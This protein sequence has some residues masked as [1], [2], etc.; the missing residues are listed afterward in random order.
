LRLTDFCAKFIL[1]KIC[2]TIAAVWILSF[3]LKA[4]SYPIPDPKLLASF[5]QVGSCINAEGELDIACAA[6]Q[7]YLIIYAD[8]ISNFDGIQFFENA[9]FIYLTFLLPIQQGA[10]RW[11]EFI[12]PSAEQLIIGAT[13]SFTLPPQFLDAQFS[14]LHLIYAELDEG[15]ITVVGLP[16]SV[17]S[18]EVSTQG[19]IWL[20]PPVVKLVLP[21]GLPN[22]IENL[23]ISNTELDVPANIRPPTSLRSLSIVGGNLGNWCGALELTENLKTLNF[24]Q[25]GTSS[26]PDDCLPKLS[27]HLIHLNASNFTSDKCAA[28]LEEELL[29]TSNLESLELKNTG[30][31]PLIFN[32]SMPVTLQYLSVNNAKYPSIA[33]LPQNLKSLRLIS[34][35]PSDLTS[36]LLP[37]SVEQLS[38]I[39][40]PIQKLHNLPLNL[41][42]LDLNVLEISEPL[43]SKDF[44][45]TL[46]S[47]IMGRVSFPILNFLPENLKY[48]DLSNNDLLGIEILPNNLQH[49]TL[50]NQFHL[51]DI[52]FNLQDLDIKV[53]E[54]INTALKRTPELPRGLETLVLRNN[55]RLKCLTTLPSTLSSFENQF[56]C[57]PNETNF[58]KFSLDGPPCNPSVICS[59]GPQIFR[60]KIYV[61]VNYNGIFDEG[62]YPL[63]HSGFRVSPEDTI[64]YTDDQGRFN[65][66]RPIY[67]T[68][69]VNFIPNPPFD[70]TAIPSSVS[71]STNLT[72][73]GGD[74]IFIPYTFAS[75]WDFQV[76]ASASSLIPGENLDL[77]LYVVNRGA[78]AFYPLT[79]TLAIPPSLQFVSADITPDIQS[80]S[81]VAWT[82]DPPEELTTSRIKIKLL[83]A[84]TLRTG[85]I[86][87]VHASLNG[88][89]PDQNQ[90][91]N[92]FQLRMVGADGLEPLKKYVNKELIMKPIS[93]EK[94]LVYV[95]RFTN[96]QSDTIKSIIL[97]DQLLSQ[98]RPESYRLISSS[99]DFTFD[100]QFENQL[101]FNFNDISLPPVTENPYEAILEVIF[102]VLA[103]DELQVDFDVFNR[104]EAVD[105]S[106][107]NIS[108]NQV[109]TRIRIN[110]SVDQRS[111]IGLQAFPNPANDVV[112]LKWN[113]IQ[114]STVSILNS[115]GQ[116]VKTIVTDGQE[117]SLQVG[118][119]PAGAYFI[120][121]SGIEGEGFG[122][123]IVNR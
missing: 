91:N 118:D 10:L 67:K 66:S 47:L 119:W 122:K 84:S 113:T 26:F 43:D 9:E 16:P 74:S 36:G 58:L 71:L 45:S 72:G 3:S 79:L 78:A 65:F 77:E 25:R 54:L 87:D 31:V 94:D 98:L 101:V 62:D 55:G 115:A 35:A 56:N 53:L 117:L 51:E 11:S 68:Y 100:F 93:S 1:M 37:N 18:L 104:A 63:S 42:F 23:Q 112:T 8:S 64:V 20:P 52:S 108:S 75:A 19:F 95:L 2:W 114:K 7:D 32:Q 15:A 24:S 83:A 76:I 121:I 88:F 4:Q 28:W 99:H 34:V 21:D 111:V 103:N 81:A 40:V 90:H 59:E 50:T 60:G 80:S 86:V 12:P 85:D 46:D 106:G 30:S 89:D 29:V 109:R 120:Q 27:S 39:G 69:Q 107:W 5:L 6:K 116:N 110:T 22:T 49:L 17:K 44:P 48:A 105:G 57:L 41:R 33:G 70:G 96:T 38:L 102:S 73:F 92:T 82:L 97:K 61:D 123:I 13:F 14:K